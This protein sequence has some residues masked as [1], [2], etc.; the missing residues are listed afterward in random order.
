[1]GAARRGVAHFGQFEADFAR[2]V[3]SRK[4]VR[5]KLQEKPF[6]LLELLLVRS[7]ELVTRDELKVA[8]WPADT[9]VE[10]DD[11]LNTAVKKL[12]AALD[13]PSAT[14]IYL[15]TVPRRGYRF[16]APV[17]WVDPDRQIVPKPIEGEAQQAD[18]SSGPAPE[19]LEA[20]TSVLR[21]RSVNPWVVF[22]AIAML[23]V[24]IFGLMRETRK[25]SF[26]HVAD[27]A[28]GHSIGSNSADGREAATNPKAYEEYQEARRYWRQRT[29]DTLAKAIEHY[30][31][32][33]AFD[34]AYADAFAG[35]ANCYVVM[36]MLSNISQETTYPKAIQA[37]ETAIRLDDSVAEAH[38]AIAEVRFYSEW[39]FLSAEREFKRTLELDPNSAQAHQWYAEFLSLMGRHNEAIAEIERAKQ[40]DPTAMIIYHQAGQIRQAARQYEAALNEYHFALQIQP[41]FGPTYSA[42]ELAYFRLHRFDDAVKAMTLADRYWNQD[43]SG[44]DDQRKMLDA[45]ARSGPRGFV[46][47]KLEYEKRHPVPVYLQARN[48]AFLGKKEDALRCLKASLAK[49]EFQFLGAQTDSEFDFLRDDPRFQEMVTRAGLPL[50]SVETAEQHKIPDTPLASRQ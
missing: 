11:G 39:N 14:P 8:L 50:R 36:P 9:F 43:G 25:G 48:Y 28:S 27:R 31:Q 22:A 42:M 40:L 6:Q 16:S 46:E 5:V 2:R 1:M 41:D 24:L 19:Q 49:R 34:P 26:F 15:E 44:S 32:A 23:F 30:Q 13:D 29:S 47:A 21:R 33:I 20:P 4:G 35:L 17:Q 18:T 37:A 45:Y 12:R 3:L 10:F 7:G 38:L